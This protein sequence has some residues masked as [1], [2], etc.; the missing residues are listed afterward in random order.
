ML[1]STK[2]VFLIQILS[3]DFPIPKNHRSPLLFIKYNC[4]SLRSI[5]L[6]NSS[7]YKITLRF[8]DSNTQDVLQ[9]SALGEGFLKGEASVTLSSETQGGMRG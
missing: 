5:F 7:N 6:I 8:L 4:A 9:S 1:E 2:K 3:T